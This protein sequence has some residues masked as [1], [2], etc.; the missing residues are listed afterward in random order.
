MVRAFLELWESA[1]QTLGTS[2]N[3]KEIRESFRSLKGAEE[4]GKDRKG[5][6]LGPEKF[7]MK[8]EE[9]SLPFLKKQSRR[10]EESGRK[11]TKRRR[12]EGKKK[13]KSW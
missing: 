3:R 2:R 7:L 9:N 11:S 13:G 4:P 10:A 5:K 1:G 6:A 8:R 12:K